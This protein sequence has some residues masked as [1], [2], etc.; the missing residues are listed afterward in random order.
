MR[1]TAVSFDHGQR[2]AVLGDLRSV[3][4]DNEA[5]TW[6]RPLF[7]DSV[8]G[9]RPV[10]AE[11]LLPAGFGRVAAVRSGWSHVLVLS[12]TGQLFTFGRNDHR[13]L[14][15]SLA[16]QNYCAHVPCSERAVQIACGA[17]HS[18]V[19]LGMALNVAV[20]DANVTAQ[21]SG[22]LLLSGWNEHGQVARRPAEEVAGTNEL[23]GP[24]SVIGAG[25]GCSF[26]CV[27]GS[28]RRVAES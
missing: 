16:G 20:A 24:F 10:A 5:A 21:E 9:T 8:S 1:H 13:Q 2:L 6:R 17:E 18:M 11:V 23:A 15:N 22:R 25:S 28:S 4:C 26:A 27:N 14:L 19:L 3:C 7:G 12:D